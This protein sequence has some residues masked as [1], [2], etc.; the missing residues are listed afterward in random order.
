MFSVSL[1]TPSV[2]T[3]LFSPQQPLNSCWPKG[4]WAS[5]GGDRRKKSQ[6]PTVLSYF[7]CGPGLTSAAG[8]SLSGSS[9]VGCSHARSARSLKGRAGWGLGSAGPLLLLFS[10]ATKISPILKLP[11][12]SSLTQG[13]RC[14]CVWRGSLC[15]PG[16]RR[17]QARPA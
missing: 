11:H 2:W 4:S 16:S 9:C 7:P 13:P 6:C 14:Q 3:L 12:P 17:A 5:G 10:G 8:M 1:N 15:L